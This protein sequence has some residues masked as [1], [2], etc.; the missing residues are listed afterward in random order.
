MRL[1]EK[2]AAAEKTITSIV[3]VDFTA[4]VYFLILAPYRP[5]GVCKTAVIATRLPFM[6]LRLSGFFLA[7]F[8]G[9]AEMNRGGQRQAA[10][11]KLQ[12]ASC[13]P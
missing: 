4:A 9:A 6:P 11:C 8:W 2:R 5:T 7:D 10:S 3:R 13:K 12:A 1:K